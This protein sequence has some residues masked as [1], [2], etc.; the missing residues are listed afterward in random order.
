MDNIRKQKVTNGKNEIVVSPRLEIT[1][2][3]T[4]RLNELRTYYTLLSMGV[5]SEDRFF[6]TT[7]QRIANTTEGVVLSISLRQGLD[8]KVFK[9]SEGHRFGRVMYRMPTEKEFYRFMRKYRPDTAI[10]RRVKLPEAM[11]DTPLV[12]TEKDLSSTKAFRKAILLHLIRS[13]PGRYYNMYLAKVLN[14]CEKTARTYLKELPIKK[15]ANF[16]EAI[17][18]GAQDMREHIFHSK[19]YASV[20]VSKIVNGVWQVLHQRSI[21]NMTVRAYRHYASRDCRI[22][23]RTRTANDYY[24]LRA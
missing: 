20:Q 15:K 24:P 1:A 19:E 9:P 13:Q 8:P 6:V 14:V 10:I 4:R 23:V 2:V 3:Q 12:V 5:K 17:V 18:N 22:T 7:L 16:I 11:T 21:L